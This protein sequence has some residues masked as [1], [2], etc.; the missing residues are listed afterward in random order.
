MP[1][2]TTSPNVDQSVLTHELLDLL[3][4]S[5][6]YQDPPPE[7]PMDPAAMAGEEGAPPPPG[8]EGL[9]EAIPEGQAVSEEGITDPSTGTLMPEVG[10]ES[11][12]GIEGRPVMVDTRS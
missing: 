5:H 9:G 1:F 3:K 12:V 10:V 11:P 6:V 7:V 4:L 8:P 2:L